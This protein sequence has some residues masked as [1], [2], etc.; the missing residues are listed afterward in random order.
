M[1]EAGAP[2]AD[3][4]VLKVQAPVPWLRGVASEAQAPVA[5][6]APWNFVTGGEGARGLLAKVGVNVS[7]RRPDIRDDVLGGE[8]AGEEAIETGRRWALDES[9][10][11]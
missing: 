6:I 7:L 3:G 5:D 2:A 11:R 8:P 4:A 9:V 1:H 10:I